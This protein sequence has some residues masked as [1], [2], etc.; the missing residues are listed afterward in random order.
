VTYFVILKCYPSIKEKYQRESGGSRKMK[1]IKG[2]LEVFVLLVSTGLLIL[3]IM[4][5]TG[6][7]DHIA[8]QVS[9]GDLGGGSQSKESPVSQEEDEAASETEEEKKEAYRYFRA[10]DTFSFVDGVEVTVVDTGK[11]TD[12]ESQKTYV[13]VELD[14]S[15]QSDANI[16]TNSYCYGFYGDDYSLGTGTID[17]GV[18]NMIGTVI[19][20]GRRGHG[21]LYEECPDYDT[22]SNIEMEFGDAIIIIKD[23]TETPPQETDEKALTYGT[24][25]YD[26][27]ISNICT[28]SVFLSMGDDEGNYT[29]D[30]I[31]IEVMGYGGHGVIDFWGILE[32]RNDGTYL[33]HGID[34]SAD[35]ICTFDPQGMSVSVA[36]SLHSTLFDAEGYYNLESVLNVDEV[37]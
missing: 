5:A 4:A 3:V 28:A 18:D 19:S 22:L 30:A 26:D 37:N 12:W 6:K 17:Y 16:I 11:E 35:V 1:I 21:R 33:A 27:G 32:R 20:K 29:G 31:S 36:H 9:G 15:N 25:V 13:Y 23:G 2:V 10:G 8:E 7:F 14:I 24:Y 34:Y